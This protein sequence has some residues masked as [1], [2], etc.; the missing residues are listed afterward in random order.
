[1]P[2]PAG[3]EDAV[4]WAIGHGFTDVTAQVAVLGDR[5]VAVTAA[6][7]PEHP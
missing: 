6:R 4:D 7:L 3:P 5:R 2:L 1:M